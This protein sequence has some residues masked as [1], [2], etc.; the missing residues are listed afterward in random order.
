MQVLLLLCMMFLSIHAGS[1][2][3][4]FF[5][6]LESVGTRSEQSEDNNTFDSL[7]VE[8]KPDDNGNSNDAVSHYTFCSEPPLPISN[9]KPVID[10]PTMS[11][12]RRELERMAC[13]LRF[14][15]RDKK[16]AQQQAD[17]RRFIARGTTNKNSSIKNRAHHLSRPKPKA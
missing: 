10:R 17:A 5:G 1:S 9:E 13:L 4:M 8:Y 14:A 15:N 16:F 6:S 3:S 7:F 2:F 12:K 11:K